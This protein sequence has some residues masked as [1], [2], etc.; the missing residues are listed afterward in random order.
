MIQ[1][2]QICKTSENEGGFKNEGRQGSSY[3][4]LWNPLYICIYIYISYSVILEPAGSRIG[5]RSVSFTHVCA[6]CPIAFK[7][8]KALRLPAFPAFSETMAEN[9]FGIVSEKAGKAGKAGSLRHFQL[10][11]P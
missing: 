11:G 2:S 8:L 3:S 5:W 10:P 6:T 1:S 7:L 9:S 4:D